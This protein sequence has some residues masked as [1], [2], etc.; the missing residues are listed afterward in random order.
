MT[1]HGGT[2]SEMTDVPWDPYQG[3]STPGGFVKPFDLTIGA[4]LLTDGTVLV[5]VAGVAMLRLRPDRQGNYASG[6]W[7]R[8]TC[9]HPTK[10]YSAAMLADGSLLTWY[11]EFGL[12]PYDVPSTERKIERY[13]PSSDT[14]SAK[15]PPWS[16]T[17][18]VDTPGTILA[19][20]RVLIG[21]GGQTTDS[22]NWGR[23]SMIYDPDDDSWTATP[24]HVTNAFALESG[25]ALR[26]DG[27]VLHFPQQTGAANPPTHKP[28]LYSPA[29]DTWTALSTMTSI[30]VHNNGLDTWPAVDMGGLLTLHD[31]D[32]I[33]LGSWQGKTAR[34]SSGGVLS[35]GPTMPTLSGQSIAAAAF[36]GAAGILPNGNWL[37]Q[38]GEIPPSDVWN[39]PAKFVEFDG[40]SFGELANQPSGSDGFDDTVVPLPNGQAMV[41]RG[42]RLFFFTP[43]SVTPPTGKAPV[44][45]SVTTLGGSPAS[46]L[47]AGQTYIVKGT[48][49]NGVSLGIGHKDEK[50]ENCN[51]PVVR[52]EYGD[53]TVVYCRTRNCRLQSDGSAYMGTDPSKSTQ[54][55]FTVPADAKNGSATLHVVAHGFKSTSGISVTIAD[56]TTYHAPL[57]VAGGVGEA[58]D[59]FY[60]GVMTRYRTMPDDPTPNDGDSV[61]E[62]VSVV[63][64][65]GTPPY[66]YALDDHQALPAGVGF[67]SGTDGA[68]LTGY[69]TAPPEPDPDDSNEGLAAFFFLLSVEATDSVG[70]TG[71]GHFLFQT[72]DGDPILTEGDS[73]GLADALDVFHDANPKT[74]TLSNPLGSTDTTS[75]TATHGRTI[76]R[77]RSTLEG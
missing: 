68:G 35:A 64:S 8:V 10:Y 2:W 25:M 58:W 15:A 54:A 33:A 52:L 69:P 26:Q 32:V 39:F 14:W 17:Y 57:V 5:N 31:G 37:L 65:A 76:G 23:R 24:V 18:R 41:P 55:D 56:G 1:L 3:E 60:D 12:S 6:S 61:Y 20:G 42:T 16:I 51:F 21:T 62:A 74:K 29:A 22:S 43:G 38:L 49:L 59:G 67:A 40:S 71:Q 34:Y 48:R 30:Q 46:T 9:R 77:F 73:A 28:Q 53:G 63:A 50:A 66:T 7:E 19:D 44:P 4:H 45:S 47:S 70:A 13:D 72:V 11:G 75:K 27:T 36:D